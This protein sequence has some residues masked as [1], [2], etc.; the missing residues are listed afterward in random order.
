ML[1]IANSWRVEHRNMSSTASPRR[2]DPPKSLGRSAPLPDNDNQIPLPENFLF[3]VRKVLSD[4]RKGQRTPPELFD[5]PLGILALKAVCID[6]SGKIQEDALAQRRSPTLRDTW[7]AYTT[8]KTDAKPSLTYLESLCKIVL[9]Q[10][11]I[12]A[13]CLTEC[14]ELELLRGMVRCVIIDDAA[15]AQEPETPRA[16]VVF[17]K[18]FFVMLG[19]SIQLPPPVY[20]RS[21]SLTVSSPAKN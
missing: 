3:D 20:S 5:C 14:M 2:E 13:C 21:K 4:N 18:A 15:R 9:S 6:P 16:L 12:I 8:C 7:D 19:G 10:Q 1:H 17:N 11:N